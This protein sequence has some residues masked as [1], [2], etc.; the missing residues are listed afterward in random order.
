VATLPIRVLLADDH[1]LVRKGIGELLAARDEFEVIGEAGEGREAVSESLRLRPDVVLM[2]LNMPN[3]DGLW[4]TSQLA[5]ELPDTRVLI[6][7]VSTDDDQLKDSLRRGA[8]GYILKSSP[9]DALYQALHDVVRGETPVPSTM[10]GRILAGM[11]S[12]GGAPA[13]QAGLSTRERE[14]L[15]FLARGDTNKEIAAHLDISE[16][17]VKAHL[18]SI[19][20]KLGVGNRVEAAGWALRHLGWP[21]A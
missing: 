12:R 20:R 3:G 14:V 6:L 21:E 4:A 13:R 10:A 11:E 7:T 8:S 1:A 17:T 9:A 2:D 16:N 18:K 15:R 19:L 5:E